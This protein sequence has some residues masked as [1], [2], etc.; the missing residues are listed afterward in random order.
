MS[1]GEN[2]KARREALGM[3]QGKLAEEVNVSQAMIC[4]IERNTKTI[5][6]PLAVEVAR[7][8]GCEVGELVKHN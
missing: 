5:S 8:L 1:I 3:P 4:Q 7:V 2:I 6:L